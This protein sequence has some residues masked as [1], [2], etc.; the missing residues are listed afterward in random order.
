MITPEYS[1]DQEFRRRFRRE[2]RAAASIQHPNVVPIYH[3]GEHEGL[4][5]V[6][7][8]YVDGTDL[9]RLLKAE[10]KLEPARAADL[11]AQ[12][13]EALDAAH[14]AGIVHRDVKPANVLIETAAD[15]M[16]ATL[17][18][19]GLMKDLGAKSQIT[20]AGSVIGTFDYAAPEQLKEGPI[21]A[22]TDVYA[23]GG[24]LFRRSRARSPTRARP[25]P[26]RCSRTST[27]R[28]PGC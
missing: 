20:Q 18:D 3:A 14:E 27:R 6:T 26:R 1:S 16:H 19:F 13:G 11:I 23:L 21:D 24:V 28:R 9:A 2:F 8:R 15:G 5:Y 4:L 7:M 22:R 10:G 25:P 17:T 12:V